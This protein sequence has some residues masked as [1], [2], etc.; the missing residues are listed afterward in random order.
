MGTVC[1]QDVFVM[2]YNVI[3]RYYRREK[4]HCWTYYQSSKLK[5]WGRNPPPPPPG[6]RRPKKPGLNRVKKIGKEINCSQSILVQK[7][8]TKLILVK[9]MYVQFSSY[10]VEYQSTSRGGACSLRN[11]LEPSLVSNFVKHLKNVTKSLH[12]TIVTWLVN[13]H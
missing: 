2:S 8:E 3:S 6:P 7:L 10:K 5:R 11:G 12:M 9:F 13:K 4:R 1:E